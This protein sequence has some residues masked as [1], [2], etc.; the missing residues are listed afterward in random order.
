MVK[1]RKTSNFVL[2]RQILRLIIFF[3][4]FH[5]HRVVW[6]GDSHAVFMRGGIRSGVD[7]FV[8]IE[9][10]LFWIGPRL[11]YSIAKSGFPTTIFF[12]FLV[13]ICRPK[14]VVISIGEI[15]VRMFLHNSSLRQSEWVHEYLVRVT[16][17][18]NA[19]RVNEVRLLTSIPVSELPP[20]DPIERRGSLRER[21]EGFNWLQAVIQNELLNNSK[22][23]KIK[24]IDLGN[25]LSGLDGTLSSIYTSDGIHVNSLGAWRVWGLIEN[26]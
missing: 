4:A 1:N 9:S 2:L 10:L 13:R 8:P 3:K 25:C 12:K 24:Y 21:L 5:K 19:L 16:E 22:F 11:M 6:I 18:I 15:D 14:L 17:L 23:D 7:D 20:S 26:S